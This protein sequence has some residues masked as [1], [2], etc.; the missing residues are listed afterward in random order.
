MSKVR[1]ISNLSNIIKTDASGNVSF[2][3]GSTTLATLNTSGQ[4]SGSS[5][6]LSSSY[7]Q[8]SSYASAFNVAGTL[9]ATTLVVQ[10]VTSSVIYS[11]GSNVFGNNIA[12]TQVMTGSVTVTGSLAVVTTGTE[13]QVNSTGVNLGNALTDSHVIS[14]SLRVNPNGLFVSGSGLVGIGT[15]SPQRTLEVVGTIRNTNPSGSNF[16]QMYNDATGAWFGTGAYPMMFETNGAERMRITASGSVGIGT[17]TPTSP[18]DVYGTIGYPSAWRYVITAT[19]PDYPTI[20]LLASN[21]GKVSVIGNNN[22]GGMYFFVSGSATTTQGIGAMTLT[23]AGVVN[24]GNGSYSPFITLISGGS[25]NYAGAINM[26]SKVDFLTLSGGNSTGYNSG[27]Y[28][29][30]YGSDRYGTNTAGMLTLGAGN[31]SSN[32]NYGYISFDT[33]NL[34]RMRISRSGYV[35]KPYN[36]AFRAYYSSNGGWSLA[37]ETFVFN[38]TEYNIG[39][40]Y[41]TSNG[42]FTAPVTGVY[43]FNFYSI[44]YGVVSSGF[45]QFQKNG[46]VMTSG[47]NIHFTS[48]VAN[49]WNDVHFITSVSLNSGDYVS[50]YNGGPT[51]QYHGRDWSSFSGYLV[52]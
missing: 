42:R 11:S 17:T 24:I 44:Y 1:D 35:T 28:I 34:E 23:S 22:D 45:I 52:G 38:T 3:S 2:V 37:N 43:Q 21:S 29:Y 27:A 40:G 19:A 31:S 30:M 39:S 47:T 8:T 14:G 18:L 16:S 32:S 26:D 20:R 5:P 48:G 36:P 33:A 51:V 41:N 50:I 46:A 15:S 9:T 12:N 25:T 4:L 49:N 7:A 6:V 10:T 13:F